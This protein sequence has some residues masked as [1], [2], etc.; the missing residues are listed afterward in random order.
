MQEFIAVENEE[1]ERARKGSN[2]P[3]AAMGRVGR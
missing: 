2:G 3:A 1:M